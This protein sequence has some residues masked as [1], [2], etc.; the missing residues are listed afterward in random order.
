MKIHSIS[1]HHLEILVFDFSL[2]AQSSFISK[3]TFKNHEEKIKNM[4]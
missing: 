3:N 2:F 1:S 4:T